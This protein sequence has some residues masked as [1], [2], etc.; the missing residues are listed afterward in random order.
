MITQCKC[1]PAPAFLKPVLSDIW[2]AGRTIDP[3]RQALAMKQLAFYAEELKIQNPYKIGENNDAVERGRQYLS[4]F[5]GVERLYRGIIEEANKSP[6]VPA[7]LVE[8][9][10]NYKQALSSPGEVQAAF[11]KEGWNFVNSAIKDPSRLT[12]GEPC[13]L[14]GM[15]AGAQLLQGVQVQTD[16]QNLYIQDYIRRWKEFVDQT[17]VD[18]FRNAADATKRLEILA[19]NRSPLL[20]AVFMIADNTNFTAKRLLAG[21]RAGR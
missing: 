21:F 20:S 18:I 10:P 15:N 13:V 3:D 4:S 14:G 8:I 11:T 7:R 5:G 16:L 17:S 2:V 19:D 12:L 1:T 9:A 6:R